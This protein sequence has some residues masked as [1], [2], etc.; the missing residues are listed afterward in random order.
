MAVDLR[1]RGGMVHDGTGAPPFPADVLIDAGRIVAVTGRPGEP[2]A[3]RVIPAE[4]LAVS[5]GFVDVHTHS[6]VSVLLDGRAQSKVHQGVTTEVTGN[7]GFSPFPLVTCHLDDHLDLLAG[8]GHDPVTPTWTDLDGYADAVTAAGVAVNVAPLVGHGQ[9]RIA[10]LGM[11]EAA[12]VDG[13]QVMERSLAELLEQGAFGL[14]TGLTYVPSRYAEWDELMAL[15]SVLAAHGSLYATHARGDVSVGLQEAAEVGVAS[16][17]KVQYSHVALNEPAMWGRASEVLERFDEV[18]Q[19]GVDIGC[20]VYPYDA[21]ASAL[22]QYLPAWVLE[23]GLQAMRS[24]L[25]SAEVF[26][27]AE[28]ELASGWG[29]EGRIPWLWDRVV[30]SR[31]VPVDGGRPTDGQNVEEAAA[32]AGMSPARFVLELCREGGNRV[33]GVLFYRSEE[34]V[35]TFLRSDL[36]VMGSDG[37]AVPFDCGDSRPHPRGFG[38]HARVLG[39]YAR[40]LGDLDLATAVRKMTGAAAERAGITDRGALRPGMAADVVVFDP[41]TVADTASFADPCRP[42]IGI[43]HVV[44]NGEIVIDAGTQ[45]PARPG[46][47][48]R[49]R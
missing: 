20:D 13:L 31:G 47:V 10:A 11:A 4:G 17:V 5:P 46:R 44:V 28:E 38:A 34:D 39:R 8:L 45:T 24:R 14:S 21:S 29:P 43:E 42:P 7:C 25:V 27:R 26:R 22:T 30:V 6:D 3:T 36:T 40:D 1:I 9:L 12:S 2:D 41:A 35:R 23:G 16:G 19:T 32:A 37:S 49:A 48:L 18:R 33:Q 15:C